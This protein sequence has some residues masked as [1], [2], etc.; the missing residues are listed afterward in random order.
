MGAPV[1]RS[2]KSA[3][4][5]A[6]Q[7]PWRLMRT[8]RTQLWRGDALPA[9]FRSGTLFF[10]YGAAV[11]PDCLFQASSGAESFAIGY[12]NGGFELNCAINGATCRL[13]LNTRLRGNQTTLAIRWDQGR[14]ILAVWTPHRPMQSV[15][16]SLPGPGLPS[17][18]LAQLAS[19]DRPVGRAVAYTALSSAAEPLGAMGGLM[20]RAKI[21][22]PR[23]L[24]PASA[25]KPGMIVN[26]ADGDLAQVVMARAIERPAWDGAEP[27]WLRAPHLGLK[28]DLVVAADQQIELY[29][30]DIDYLLGTDRVCIRAADLALGEMALRYHN[31][32]VSSLVQIAL[33]RPAA[34]LAEGLAVRSQDPW[35]GCSDVTQAQLGLLNGIPTALWPR[36]GQVPQPIGR[37]ELLTLLRFRA[38]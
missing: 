35:H 33:D 26:T 22:T 8:H 38:A 30:A 6:L 18:L 10:G 29:G 28:R 4:A 16:C 27:I 21:T 11:V 37:E 32:P 25:L 1:F 34:I 5:H 15:E 3:R 24:V 23:G 31:A 14:L 20:A 7:A 2:S 36:P 13:R 9:C 19:H 12:H 17:T